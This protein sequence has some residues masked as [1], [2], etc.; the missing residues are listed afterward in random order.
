MEE[1]Y[2]IP[3]ILKRLSKLLSLDKR[4]IVQIYGFSVLIG[5]VN[6]S[7][8]LGFQAII[9]LIQSGKISN[10]WIILVTL[11][12]IG[13]AFAG[14]MQVIQLRITENIQQ[15]IFT[16]SAFD[17]SYRIPKLK[18]SAIQDKYA[19]ELVNRFFD[20]LTIQKGIA[21][22][23]IDISTATLQILF[24]LLLLSLYHPVFILFSIIL[25]IILYLIFKNSGKKGI[26]TSLNES[27]YKYK[28]AH[29]LE[30][31][32]RTMFTFK[33]AG[34][35][36]LHIHKTD[37]L[38]KEY[39]QHRE[40]H[41][42]VL[43]FQYMNLIGF[44]VFIIAGLLIIGGFLVINGEINL[45]QFV[46]SEIII[47][48]IMSNIEKLIGSIEVIYDVLTSV[49]KVGQITDIPLDLKE[50]VSTKELDRYPTAFVEL[51]N[52]VFEVNH[53]NVLDGIS[54]DF[55]P[56]DRVC[57]TGFSGGGKSSLLQLVAGVYK[58]KSGTVCVNDFNI[59]NIAHNEYRS[60]LGNCFRSEGIFNATLRDNITL[61]RKDISE[62]R[63]EEVIEALDF[64]QSVKQLSMELET[65]ISPDGKEFSKNTM[66]KILLARSIVH[67]PKL[68]LL[69]YAFEYFSN[70]AKRKLLTYLCD[71]KQGWTI[72][73]VS[74]DATVAK[75]CD[76]VVVLENGKILDEGTFDE[77]T[78]KPAFKHLY[79]L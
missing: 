59:E 70:D 44:K 36:N 2:N 21:K 41:F 29:W 62:Q 64:T 27:K 11:V 74:N 52:V 43:I 28:T 31:I 13:A 3:K 45:G 69:E 5:V 67:Q 71:K 35:T 50:G 37:I 65:E 9:N 51:R 1:N 68:L 24:A 42:K 72:I 25:I 17:F 26:I 23:L 6:L 56:Y 33:L 46:A 34:K 8:P 15:K 30:E 76:K 20:T 53:T 39:I 55:K 22:L 73:V 18:L 40:N 10:A 63:L 49:E 4:E 66:Q 57:L 79:N 47:L 14:I 60:I 32:A 38:T 19:P 16:R 7:M 75:A 58:P 61:G 78:Q 54:I 12:I 48:L 77:I